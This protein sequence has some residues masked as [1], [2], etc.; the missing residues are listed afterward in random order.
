MSDREAADARSDEQ[1]P[2]EQGRRRNLAETRRLLR[3]R[4]RWSELVAVHGVCLL[5]GLTFD[6]D[7]RRALA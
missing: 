4:G 1:A 7:Q 5:G 3:R 6:M 2:A